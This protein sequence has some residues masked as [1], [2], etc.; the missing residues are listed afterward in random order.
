[1]SI[2]YGNIL[3]TVTNTTCPS[4]KSCAAGSQC[5]SSSQC[6]TGNCCAY[7]VNLNFNPY[8]FNKTTFPGSLS[9]YNSSGWLFASSQAAYNAYLTGYY[10]TGKYCLPSTHGATTTSFY[11]TLYGY[12]S[13]TTSVDTY[14]C[15]SYMCSLMITVNQAETIQAVVAAFVAAAS[16]MY[17]A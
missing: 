1:M 7:I 2:N 16:L 10:Y 15:V 9:Q 5:T 3:P 17:I 14:K 12:G 8:V 4:G 13:V 6:T 11:D